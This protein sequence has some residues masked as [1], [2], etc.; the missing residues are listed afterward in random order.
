MTVPTTALDVR[1]KVLGVLL[2]DARQTAGRPARECAERLGLSPAAYAAYESG[3]KSP[4]LPELEVLAYFLETP[5]AHFGGQVT[6]A[7]EAGRRP[8]PPD[9]EVLALRHRMVGARLRQAR[10]DAELSLKDFAFSLGITAGLLSDYEYGHKPIPFPELE[11]VCRQLGLDPE[12]LLESQGVVGEWDSAQ[13]L[14]RRFRRLPLELREF[15]ANPANEHYLRL[16]QRLSQ[17]PAEQLR[18]I[19][20]GLLDITY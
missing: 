6:L 14:F 10:Q 17:M 5:L 1:A 20:A 19:A 18:A 13:R 12:D 8:P 9:P 2:R 7:D 11:V 16:A 3:E 15:A 4:S